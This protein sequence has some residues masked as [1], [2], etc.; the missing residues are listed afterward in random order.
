MEVMR[1]SV[2]KILGKI[3]LALSL[4]SLMAC[5]QQPTVES[6]SATS[7]ASISLKGEWVLVDAQ[8]T[9]DGKTVS[10]FDPSYKMIKMFTDSHFAYLASKSGRDRVASHNPTDDVKIKSYGQFSAGGGRYSLTGNQ[11]VEHVEFCSVAN[12]EGMSIAFKVSLDGDT[13]IQE[14][15]YPMVAL[16]FGDKDGYL[17]ETYKRL[18]D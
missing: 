17:V 10:W 11:Y 15:T 8:F 13:L 12:Y 3:V 2:V 16:G 4:L 14:G 18:A 5:S 6:A 1:S 7:D 9:R